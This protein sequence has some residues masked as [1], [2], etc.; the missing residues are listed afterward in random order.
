MTLLQAKSALLSF[1]DQARAASKPIFF[2][3]SKDDVFL[4]VKADAIK[5]IAKEF[6]H[7]QFTDIVQLMQSQVHEER[8]LANA[9]LCHNYRKASEKEKEKIYH[10]YLQNRHYIRDWNGVD[11]S[12]PY[13]IGAYLLEKDKKILY[14][15][16]LSKVIW[17]RRIA[18]VATWWFIRHGHFEDTLKLS[19]LLLQDKEDL[20]QKAVGWML[21]EVGKRD[22]LS[23]KKFLTQ[24]HHTMPRIMLRYAIEKFE[25]AV[26]KEYLTKAVYV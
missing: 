24:H 3:N 20:I 14:Q 7:L 10:F 5:K 21:R 1:K 15:L 25:P 16:A 23:L 2:K 11:D 26:R 8:S 9:I 6:S 12:A 22:V 4:G 17:E 18:I 19:E 13:I